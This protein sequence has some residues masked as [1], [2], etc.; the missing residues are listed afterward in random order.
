MPSST[1]VPAH[2][3]RSATLSDVASRA[4]VSLNTASR[5]LNGQV[6]GS[7]PKVR[8]RVERIQQIADE[9][10]YRANTAARATASG[11]FH[12]AGLLFRDDGA[13]GRSLVYGINKV[14]HKQGMRLI[15]SPLHHRAEA[16][17]PPAILREM[18]VDGLLINLMQDVP[19]GLLDLVGR[20]GTPAV[21]INAKLGQDCVYP[22]DAGMVRQVT[23]RLLK[24]GHRR[25]AYLAYDHTRGLHYSGHTRHDAYL[26]VM[27]DT[28]LEPMVLL[29]THSKPP[30]HG[31]AIDRLLDTDR[32]DRPT[33]VVCG[34]SALAHPL[35]YAA[36]VR[37]IRVPD[38]LAVAAV[39]DDTQDPN[40]AGL[41]GV[42]VP[43]REIG[44]RAATMLRQRIET[45]E[46]QPVQVVRGKLVTGRTVNE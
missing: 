2:S 1:P 26:A 22:D 40:G 11:R 21:W 44:E 41:S 3:P 20:G 25:I 13:V 7:Y 39:M 37:S 34:H 9:L 31:P 43:F 18:S 10:G 29:E 19:E 46:S 6:K 5:M 16:A 17:D 28:G 24:L 14:L 45:Q 23:E 8:K 15:L 36:A 12:A 38:E 27:Q 42:A 4:G 32:A 35:L 33:A 30:P